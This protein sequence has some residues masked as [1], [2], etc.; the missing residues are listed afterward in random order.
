MDW[1]FASNDT[2]NDEVSEVTDFERTHGHD[3]L[4][5]STRMVLKIR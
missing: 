2:A 4:Q 3:R 1:T 5:M